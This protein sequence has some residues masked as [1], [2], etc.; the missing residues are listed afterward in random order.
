MLPFLVCLHLQLYVTLHAR[1]VEHAKHLEC[2]RALLNGQE[3][4]VSK[5]NK[6][7]D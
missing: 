3:I 5:V 2:A 1:M 7:P 6:L 4:A